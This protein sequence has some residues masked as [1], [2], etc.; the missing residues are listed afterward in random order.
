MCHIPVCNFSHTCKKVFLSP[1]Y[2]VLACTQ[3]HGTG[4]ITGVYCKECASYRLL[5]HIYYCKIQNKGPLENFHP[6]CGDTITIS[7]ALL[8]AWT[9]ASSLW[10]GCVDK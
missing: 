1:I 2:T 9:C 10:Y 8:S 5:F 4:N 3:L 7:K 6:H